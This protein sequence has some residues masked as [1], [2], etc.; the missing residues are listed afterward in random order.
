MENERVQNTD[1]RDRMSEI[2]A[3]ACCQIGQ[4]SWKRNYDLAE[5]HQ[6]ANPPKADKYRVTND[7]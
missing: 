2:N 3:A 4:F 1:V 6:K 5:F 7:K